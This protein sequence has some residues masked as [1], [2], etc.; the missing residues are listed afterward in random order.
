MNERRPEWFD[1]AVTNIIDSLVLRRPWL[2]DDIANEVQLQILEQE[3]KYP[4]KSPR[5]VLHGAKWRTFDLIYR[6]RSYNDRW[7]RAYVDL[8]IESLQP[9]ELQIF[10]EFILGSFEDR[11]VHQLDVQVALGTLSDDEFIIIV[12]KYYWRLSDD[13]ISS[14]F[15]L[16]RSRITQRRIKVQKYLAEWFREAGYCKSKD[17]EDDEDV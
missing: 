15:G 7:R 3:K 6:K 16:E 5:Q 17:V 8:R 2:A 11:L 4:K 10:P 1:S 14:V 9:D 13:V 12:L